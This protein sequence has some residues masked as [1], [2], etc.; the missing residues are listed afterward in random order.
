EGITQRLGKRQENIIPFWKIQWLNPNGVDCSGC[1]Q[2]QPERKGKACQHGGKEDNRTDDSR[3]SLTHGES[4]NIDPG[5]TRCHQYQNGM[6]DWIEPDNVAQP[7]D[8]R[9]HQQQLAQ[10][11]QDQTATQVDPVAGQTHAEHQQRERQGGRRQHLHQT[12]ERRGNHQTA[13]IHRCPAHQPYDQR[14][15]QTAEQTAPVQLATAKEGVVQT[16]QG[17][18]YQAVED[19]YG[20][21]VDQTVH[22][23]HHGDQRDAHQHIVRIACRQP[24]GRGPPQAPVHQQVDEHEDRDGRQ[25]VQQQQHRRHRPAEIGTGQPGKQQYGHHQLESDDAQ[26]GIA[27]GRKYATCAQKPAKQDQ[28]ENGNQGMEYSHAALLFSDELRRRQQVYW[29]NP[30]SRSKFLTD[31]YIYSCHLQMPLNDSFNGKDHP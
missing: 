23:E 12:P 14:I 11:Q 6:G 4:Q 7:Q 2:Y 15:G 31:S 13:E 16:L 26:G 10:S 19:Q 1:H 17:E 29:P 25:E 22:T 3:I 30:L 20:E 9:R 21:Q 24:H 28:P 27:I 5:R 8:Q 18:Q